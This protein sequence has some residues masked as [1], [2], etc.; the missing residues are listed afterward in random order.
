MN[1]QSEFV[2]GYSRHWLLTRWWLKCR[3]V[4]L[5]M[6]NGGK[7]SGA[8]LYCPTWAKPL[9]WLYCKIVG[10]VALEPA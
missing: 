6:P 5:E 3:P 2:V 7:M 4:M 9:D 10:E 1:E 8:E